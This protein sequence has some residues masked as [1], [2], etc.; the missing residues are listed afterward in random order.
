MSGCLWWRVDGPGGRLDACALLTRRVRG[1][2]IDITNL[3]RGQTDY[4]YLP[5]RSAAAGEELAAG[6]SAG[7]RAIRR[8]WRLRVDQLP[9]R[10]PV[11]SAVAAALE[12]VD[13]A[14]GDPSP[15]VEL[16]PGLEPEKYMSSSMRQNVRTARNRLARDGRSA[17]Y[18][19]EI[20]PAGV[21]AFQPELEAVWR[22]RDEAVGRRSEAD[23]PGG[24][25]FFLAAV[26][27]LANR[28]E[29]ELAALLVDG[30]MAAFAV[31]LLDGASY[32]VWVARIAPEFAAYSP[33]HLVTRSLLDRAIAHGC[34]ELDW[35]R[36]QE[37]Y[38]LQTA[39]VIRGREHLTAWSSPWLRTMTEGTK[40]LRSRL[41]ARR[42][43][44]ARAA[45]RA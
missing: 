25:G 9:E 35:M 45:S 3:G 16:R 38:K 26:R 44:R 22:A 20:S 4:L 13:I 29:V 19:H 18:V 7:L 34:T 42:E 33:G 10:D 40:T 39:T 14:P 37:P 11:A 5:A 15:V 41:H 28:S 2:I 31:S 23:D 27:R 36:G 32:R 43:E 12:V 6:I 8:P 21:G 17:E 30:R 1:G 24:L